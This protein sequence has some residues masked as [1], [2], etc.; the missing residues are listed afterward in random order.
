MMIKSKKLKQLA[1]A[2]TVFMS[3]IIVSATSIYV[4]DIIVRKMRYQYSVNVAPKLDSFDLNEAYAVYDSEDGVYTTYYYKNGTVVTEA[5][6][7]D[8][9]LLFAP[10]L[11]CYYQYTRDG[12]LTF[13]SVGQSE[14]NRKNAYQYHMYKVED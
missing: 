4:Y 14:F 11:G 8:L 13:I 6:N 7:D 10:H 5:I 1:I 3:V 9:I 12:E 2:F